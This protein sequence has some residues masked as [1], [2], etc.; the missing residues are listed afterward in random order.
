MRRLSVALLAVTLFVLSVAAWPAG[1]ALAKSPS[2]GRTGVVAQT[3]GAPMAHFSFG[4]PG[5]TD[6]N[7]NPQVH[8]AIRFDASASQGNALSY[9]WNFGDS[10]PTVTG[11]PA[12]HAFST[13]DDFTVTL[14][15]TDSS[16][17]TATTSQSVR[18][19]PIVQALVA[20]PPLQQVVP[21][22]AVPLQLYVQAPGP[23]TLNAQLSAGGL[24][25]SDSKAFS[26]K[27]DLESV[28]LNG[29]VA[30]ETDPTI[31]QQIIQT[32]GGSVSLDGKV[33]FDITYQ[34]SA[35]RSVDLGYVG[36][37]Q[38]DVDATKGTWS[39]TY[40]N[41]SII[42]GTTDPSEPDVNGYYMNGDPGFH[43][44]DDPLVRK[45]AI[46]AARAGGTFPSDPAQ[47]MEN[48]YAYVGG[49]FNSDDPAQIEPDNVVAKKIASGELVP[50]QR[51][52]KYICISQTYFLSSL[53]RTIG[54]AS[55]EL[56]IG[57]ANGTSQDPNTGV[58]TV[59]YVQEGATQVWF[60]NSWH[61]YDTWLRIR[62]LDDYLVRKYAYRAW[63]AFSP[64]SFELEAKDGSGLGLYGHDFAI[65]EE[66]GSPA[67][68][69]MWRLVQQKERDG[70]TVDG[71]PTS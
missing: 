68:P 66:D 29:V 52:E 15:V 58:W 62:N 27:D 47:A 31:A 69:D 24:I 45:Y 53:A 49:L 17:Q 50:G 70:I 56:T 60:A 40:P 23:K 32:P 38:K 7:Q 55:R 34:T 3:A 10:S 28:P 64:Q 41:F 67:G 18:V 12:S 9:S 1:L 37:L 35:G 54:L 63:Y 61:L 71:F 42:T 13:V 14:T 20:T 16:G 4:V 5:V 33:N 8:D 25:T 26:T 39:I 59:S 65:Y 46:Q 19:V 30:N 11:T 36:S 2:T 22:G 21:A 6:P 48:I 57:L 44:P 43:H 51:S